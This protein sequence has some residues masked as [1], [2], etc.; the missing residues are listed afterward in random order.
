LVPKFSDLEILLNDAA[1]DSATDRRAAILDAAGGVFMEKGFA[2]ATTL[3]IAQAAHISKRDLYR[4][5][6]SK[7]GILEALISDYTTHMTMPAMEPPADFETFFNAIEAFGRSLL[8]HLVDEKRVTFYRI[9][10][11]EAHRAPEFAQALTQQGEESVTASVRAYATQA[12]MS[13]ALPLAR[14][15]ASM[16]CFFAMLLSPVQLQVVL[17]VRAPPAPGE[18]AEIAAQAAQAA[19]IVARG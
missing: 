9:A 1:Q 14:A 12:V 17:G 2:A 18:I 7:R 5:F 3:A 19:R 8:G 15:Q 16:N 4:L 11:A 10:I 6:G 13:G